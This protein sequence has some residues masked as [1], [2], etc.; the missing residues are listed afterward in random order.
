M[1]QRNCCSQK[2]PDQQ[3]L[4]NPVLLLALCLWKY[5]AFLIL[6]V[7]AFWRQHGQLA[8]SYMGEKECVLHLFNRLHTLWMSRERCLLRAGC[9]QLIKFKKS[10]AY[11]AAMQ[12]RSRISQITIIWLPGFHNDVVVLYVL[13]LQGVCGTRFLG[14]TSL[15]GVICSC[16]LSEKGALTDYWRLV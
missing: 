12:S 10:G 11:Y 6:K 7:G 13:S 5:D 14:G 3:W 16:R 1:I 15:L 2:R 9:A 8:K 4:I